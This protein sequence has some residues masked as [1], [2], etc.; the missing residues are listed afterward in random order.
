[1]KRK[2]G[3]RRKNAVPM[4]SY[5]AIIETCDSCNIALYLKT[6]E[7]LRKRGPVERRKKDLVRDNGTVYNRK[8]ANR[9][10]QIASQKG[11]P[12]HFARTII[13]REKKK[14]I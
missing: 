8:K 9:P 10:V 1:M 2:G 5:S 12:H 11:K 14:G 7:D 13:G 6:L 4:P 3:A